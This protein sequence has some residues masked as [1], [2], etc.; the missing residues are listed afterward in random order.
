[1]CGAVP[2]KDGDSNRDAMLMSRG[3]FH[4]NAMRGLGEMTEINDLG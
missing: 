1:M 2:H 4:Y 3:M